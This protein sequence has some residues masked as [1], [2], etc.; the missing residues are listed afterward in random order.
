[1]DFQGENMERFC[2]VQDNC[3]HWYVI[4]VLQIPNWSR[5]CSYADNDE[6]NWNVP[7]FAKAVGGSPILVS[8]V[9]PIIET[10]A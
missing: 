4:P 1:M 5:F 8:F 10:T 9:D 2:L 6:R 3:S 7:E